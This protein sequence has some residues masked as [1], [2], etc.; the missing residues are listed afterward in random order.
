MTR[1]ARQECSQLNLTT[2]EKGEPP[3][4]H[5]IVVLTANRESDV[6]EIEQ[7]LQESAGLSREEPGCERFEVYH[8]QS[9]NSVFLLSEWWESEDAWKAHRERC[10]VQEIYMP[11][12]LP[13]VDRTPHISSLI[14]SG[15]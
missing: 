13:L 6:S 2:T 10:A 3:L 9:D 11:K 12:V 4:F 1:G 8:S 5:I 7:L 15:T 14:S